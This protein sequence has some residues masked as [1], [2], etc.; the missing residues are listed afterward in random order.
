MNQGAQAKTWLFV[1][2]A[3]AVVGVLLALA[4]VR[5][6][7]ELD[8]NTPEGTVQN[9]LQA[10]SDRDYEGAFNLID[11]VST[12]GCSPSDLAA[13]APKE[14]FTATLGESETTGQSAF[15]TVTI[16]QGS[17]RGGLE[18]AISSFNEFFDLDNGSGQWKII[19][20]PWPY[21]EWRCDQ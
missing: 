15:V 20:S 13:A 4:L 7:V 21:F 11:P 19:G 3:V 2:G 16:R 14:P 5:E 8:P 10:V 18:S 12:E 1:G 17:N 6:P 9:Y